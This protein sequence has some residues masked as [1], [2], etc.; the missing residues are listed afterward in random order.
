MNVIN[1]IIE[2]RNRRVFFSSVI[3]SLFSDNKK[4]R[5]K[6]L[7]FETDCPF[8]LIKALSMNS[9]SIPT[10]LLRKKRRKVKR[11]LLEMTL[12]DFS[13]QVSARNTDYDI[14]VTRETREIRVMCRRGPAARGCRG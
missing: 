7:R 2:L 14:I 10:Y 11:A 1:L 6:I 4:Y 5:I 3:I 12:F 8:V 9:S 13:N